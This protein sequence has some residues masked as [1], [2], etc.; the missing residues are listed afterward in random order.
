[1]LVD[2]QTYSE[3]H[4]Q[5]KKI[6]HENNLTHAVSIFTVL[7]FSAFNSAFVT[8]ILNF[9]FKSEFFTRSEILDLL[10]NSFHFIFASSM[11]LANLL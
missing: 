5:P 1:M 2:K 3:N 11:S 6:Y 9:M 10:A 4:H 8:N 7:S